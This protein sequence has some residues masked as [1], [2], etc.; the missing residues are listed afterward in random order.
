MY[1]KSIIRVNINEVHSGGKIT[2]GSVVIEVLTH[3]PYVGITEN[4]Y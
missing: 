3:P 2:F 1:E 4:Q